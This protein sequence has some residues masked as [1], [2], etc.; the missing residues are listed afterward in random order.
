MVFLPYLLEFYWKRRDFVENVVENVGNVRKSRDCRRNGVESACGFCLRRNWR[1]KWLK[2][3]VR[4]KC[5]EIGCHISVTLQ[6]LH[7]FYK[8]F[9]L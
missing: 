7:I 2:N 5:V 1:R 9:L 6:F 4:R 3:H 8:N